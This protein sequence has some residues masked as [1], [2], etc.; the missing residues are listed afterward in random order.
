MHQLENWDE[1]YRIAGIKPNY[2]RQLKKRGQPFPIGVLFG[3]PVAGSIPFD[4]DAAFIRATLDLGSGLEQAVKGR[5][6]RGL[7]VAARLTYL[8][9]H[10]L[11][12]GLGRADAERRVPVFLVAMEDVK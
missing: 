4:L 8:H 3:L 7:T 9:C 11:L 6:E 1:A 2:G 5:L 12:T 10:E